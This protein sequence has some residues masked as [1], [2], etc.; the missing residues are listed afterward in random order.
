MQ[1]Q[2]RN[3]YNFKKGITGPQINELIEFA[4]KDTQVIKFTSD[5]KR[6]KNI[7][8][9][10]AW[11]KQ[12][13]FYVLE[14]SEGNLLGIIWFAKSKSAE[15]RGYLFTFAIRIYPP[16][17]G[18]GYGLNFMQMAFD[19]FINSK[20]YIESKS[21]GVWLKTNKENARAINLYEKFGF[22]KLPAPSEEKVLMIFST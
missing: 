14:S 13:T 7:D 3:S 15:A 12:K 4:T 22:K 5:A 11:N 19:D 17:R 10:N 20:A 9:F 1:D 6:F 18:K 21:L 8:T 2:N 16:V